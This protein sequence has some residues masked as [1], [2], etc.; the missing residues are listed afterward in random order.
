MGLDIY[1][2]RGDAWPAYDVM[3][4]HFDKLWEENERR[5][6]KYRPYHAFSSALDRF[7]DAHIFDCPEEW[8]NRPGGTVFGDDLYGPGYI[9]RGCMILSTDLHDRYLRKIF[10]F[11]GSGGYEP[12]DWPAVRR[13]ASRVLDLYRRGEAGT[14]DW[15]GTSA[16]LIL[17]YIVRVSGWILEEPDPSVYRACYSR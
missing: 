4:A 6:S 12:Q 11:S 14:A 5:N 15:P 7:M 1:I 9:A 10:S 17:E 16:Q 2:V 8:R 13:E 3:C